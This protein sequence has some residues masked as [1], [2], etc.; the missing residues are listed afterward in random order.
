MTAGP[1]LRVARDGSVLRVTFDRPA[2]LNALT[3]ELLNS[4]AE[5]VETAGEH[6]GLRAIV[7][8]GAGRAFS[9]GADLRGSPN[10]SPAAGSGTL[11]AVNRLVRAVRLVPLPVLAAVNG[12]AVGGGCSIAL[13]AD[14]VLARESAYFMLSFTNIGLMPDGGAS[15]LVPDAVGRARAA[16]M[17]MLG[18][19]IPA[20]LAADWGLIAH[21]VP[22]ET[23]GSEVER[24]TTRLA[25]GPTVAYAQTKRALN[26]ATLDRLERAFAIEAAGQT[27]LK[28]TAD[29]TE[30]VS[31]FRHK[32]KP[33]FLGE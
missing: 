14:I 6:T 25:Q 22:D 13:A 27:V 26:A 21:A 15:V 2:A 16:R 23:F 33:R 8:T 1:G 20:P 32:R 17:A 4:A 19:R 30:G 9:S 29:F 7:L 5:A 24:L 31:A 12:P 11:D 3:A 10:P 28:G 18:E